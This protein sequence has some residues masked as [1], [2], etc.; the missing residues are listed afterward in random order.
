MKQSKT[1]E[2]YPCSTIFISNLISIAIYF[3]G[4]YI[5]Y[6]LGLIW[7]ILYIIYILVLEFRLISMH[8]V[9]CY[10]YGKYCAFGMGKISALFFKKGSPDK[11]IR[12]EMTWKDLIPDFLVSVI[13]FVAGIVL[14]ILDFSWL[15][16]TL[17]ALLAILTS[18][19]NSFVRGSLACK[20]CRQRELGCPAEKLFKKKKK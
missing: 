14:L 7:L 17:I 6:Q 8:C 1:F 10:Y 15:L 19:G 20:F 16:L 4:A 12:A 11:F 18:F 2:N 3:I 9:N 5:I 13:P